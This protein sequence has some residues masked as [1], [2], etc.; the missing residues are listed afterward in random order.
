MKFDSFKCKKNDLIKI[1]SKIIDADFAV[2][3]KVMSDCIKI[4]PIVELDGKNFCFPIIII[5]MGMVF[6]I[7][8]LD[9]ANLLFFADLKNPHISNAILSN[10]NKRRNAYV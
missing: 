6:S 8:K 10:K 1:S 2:V 5:P 3:H 7:E 4:V 9:K